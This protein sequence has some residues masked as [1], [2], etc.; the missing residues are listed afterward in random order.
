VPEVDADSALAVLHEAVDAVAEALACLDDWGPSG[1]RHGQ[2][3]CDVAADQAALGVLRKAGFGVLSEESGL[4]NADRPLL[5][6]LDPVDGS[7]NAAAGIPWF[8]TSI[9]LLDS[10]GPFVAVVANQADGRRYQAIRGGGATCDGEVL[11]PSGRPTAAEALVATSGLPVGSPP[12]GQTRMLGAAALDMCSVAEGVLDAFVDLVPDA[13]GAWDY[14]GAL[15]VCEEAGAVVADAR[16]REL[17]VRTHHERR[18]PVAAA[19]EGLLAELLAY[20]AG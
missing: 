15:L 5:A 14:T 11:V 10:E 6:V 1:A 3:L 17:V 20:R 7:T 12:W 16:G 4:E 9:A 2:Y 8:A 18:T 13:L 19:S